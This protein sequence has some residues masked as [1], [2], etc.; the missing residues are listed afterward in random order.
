MEESHFVHQY[1]NKHIMISD[2]H[3]SRPMMTHVLS[4][5]WGP[6]GGFNPSEP[7]AR[8]VGI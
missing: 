4:G 1:I 8:Q 7:Y 2:L 3:N 6:V 5:Q